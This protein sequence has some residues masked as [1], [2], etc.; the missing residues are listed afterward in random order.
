MKGMGSLFPVSTHW[1]MKP[2]SSLVKRWEPRRSHLVVRFGKPAFDEAH[3]RAVGRREERV[4][5]R[6]ADEPAVDSGVL[7]GETFTV[8]PRVVHQEQMAG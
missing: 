7:C 3:P 1:M 8:Y 4:I 5:A 2:S 6:V